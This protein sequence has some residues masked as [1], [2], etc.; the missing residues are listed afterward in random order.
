VRS[1]GIVSEPRIIMDTVY[2]YRNSSAF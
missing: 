2:V 1:L